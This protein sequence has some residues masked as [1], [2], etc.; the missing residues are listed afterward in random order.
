MSH[1]FG[2]FNRREQLCL[3]ALALIV[4]LY[5]LYILLWAPLNERRAQLVIRNQ[6]TAESLQR[7]DVM[8]SQVLHLRANGDQQHKTR[9]LVSVVNQGTS[10]ANL[11]VSRLQPGNRGDIQVRLENADFIRVMDWLYEVE[12]VQ[13]LLLLEVS[14]T[15]G[16]GAGRVNATIRI[17]QGQ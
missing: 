6:A 4:P 13:A 2:R 1:W 3:L 14:I 8:V 15:Q 16:G 10:A 7:V 17:G 5:L 11:L 9:N 12:Q